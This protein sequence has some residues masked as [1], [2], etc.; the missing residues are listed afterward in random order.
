MGN[1]RILGVPADVRNNHALDTNLQRT[2]TPASYVTRSGHYNGFS[3][4]QKNGG[5]VIS[6]T[7]IIL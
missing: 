5:I 3:S 1:L 6:I 4:L 2:P 7:V